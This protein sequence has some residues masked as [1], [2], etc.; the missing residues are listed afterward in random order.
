MV[1]KSN[2]EKVLDV[3]FYDPTGRFYIREIARITGLNPNTILNISD[4]LFRENLIKREKKKHVVELFANVENKNF[5]QLKRISNLKKIYGSGLVDFLIE[6]CSPESIS[7]IGS[8]S[9][10]EDIK[11][12]DIDIVVISKKRETFSLLDYEVKLGRKIHLIV[13]DNK[14]MSEEFFTN[15]INGI[16]LYGYIARK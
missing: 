4:A 16:V 13:T 14:S 6:K 8:Y 2:Y 11:K 1:K 10:G 3:F 9:N 7:I 12:S 5:K 15:L